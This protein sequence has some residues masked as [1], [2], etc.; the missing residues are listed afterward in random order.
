MRI[1]GILIYSLTICLVLLST[2]AAVAAGPDKVSQALSEVRGV[3]ADLF[4]RKSSVLGALPGPAELAAHQMRC[5]PAPK[6]KAGVRRE[7]DFDAATIERV[8]KLS[9]AAMRKAKSRS[10]RVLP[11]GVTGAYVTEAA[12]KT[13]FLVLHVLD[14][15]PA[16]GA[17]RID[18]IIIGANGRL[19]AD[20]EDP[21]PEMGNPLF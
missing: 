21:R 15:T 7:I 8:A 3:K 18:D 4:S 13:E 2:G 19:F 1:S 10:T 5:R 11:L 6:P 17:L 20:A 9:P 12:G 16:A 14:K